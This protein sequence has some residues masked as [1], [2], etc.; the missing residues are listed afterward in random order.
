M[1]DRD[2]DSRRSRDDDDDR[3]G[4]GGGSTRRGGVAFEYRSRDPDRTRARAEAGSGNDSYLK[5]DVRIYKPVEGLNELR[6]LPPTW[7]G[8]EHYGGDIHVHFN[9]GPDNAAYLC[10]WKMKNKPCP[11]C[12]E[13]KNAMAEGDADYA[14][15]LRASQR[16][17][18]YVLDRKKEREGAMV[19]SIG[20]RMDQD[21]LRLCTDPKTN[22]TL[23]I[24][25]PDDGY[26]LSFT[27]SEE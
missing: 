19:W 26:D 24:D 20:K 1:S 14:S 12:D 27:R 13:R 22:E 7:D 2:R 9:I 8:A 4:R 16:V 15:E 5:D 23:E 21:I 18:Q 10:L 25:K 11:V 3:G 17:V 6:I